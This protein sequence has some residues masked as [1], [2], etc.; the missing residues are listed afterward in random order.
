MRSSPTDWGEKL[1]KLSDIN[2]SR[3]CSEWQGRC[4]VSGRI[5]KSR[6][7]IMLTANHI[8]NAL[9]VPLPKD[10]EQLENSFQG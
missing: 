4:I 7:N 3:N 5:S 9:G 1:K 6:H 10:H 8:M 2:W